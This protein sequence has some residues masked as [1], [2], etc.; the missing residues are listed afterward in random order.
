MF[1]LTKLTALPP[2][3]LASIQDLSVERET[4]CP[5]PTRPA[6]GGD[7]G[8]VD[9]PTQGEVQ[10]VGKCLEAWVVLLTA[11]WLDQWL[12]P[13]FTYHNAVLMLYPY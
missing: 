9:T 11:E 13:K 2:S 3:H 10:W 12:L 4:S 1:N 8:A 5:F 6:V 7:G